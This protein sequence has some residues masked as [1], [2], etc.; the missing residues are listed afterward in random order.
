MSTKKK[1]KSKALPIPGKQVTLS[2]EQ[3]LKKAIAFQ[4]DG[5]L[6]QA[7]AIYEN[8][9][10]KDPRQ[11][12]AIHFL[13]VI[14]LQR[15]HF[16]E[17][18]DYL[19][20]AISINPHFADAL[21]HRGLTYKMLSKSALALADYSKAIELNPNHQNAWLERGVIFDGMDRLLESLQCFEKF[22]ELTKVQ[23]NKDFLLGPLNKV[24]VLRRL[25]RFEQAI[26]EAD[27]LIKSA[28]N[29]PLAYSMKAM[30]LSDQNQFDLALKLSDQAL[31]CSASS[32]GELGQLYSQRGIIYRGLWQL[33]NAATALRRA[34]EF[35]PFLIDAYSNLG[36][37]LLD[38]GKY[39][40]AISIFEKGLSINP[41]HFASH[42]NLGVAK[43]TVGDLP[44]GY[45][46]YEW[47]KRLQNWYAV[48]QQAPEW[49]GEQWL[50][51]KTILV[52]CE[53]GMGDTI[54]FARYATILA[55]IAGRVILQVQEPLLS[56]M[57]SL[58]GNIDLVPEKAPL[59]HHDFYC[60][61]MSL[62]K[63]FGTELQSI[64]ARQSYLK[65]PDDK[66]LAWKERLSTH[67]KK[68]IGLVWS[69]GFRQDQ[70]E[71][72]A[73]NNRRNI[74]LEKILC[75]V[76]DDRFDWF[77]L[78]KGDP[79]ESELKRY[80]GL[81]EHP[82]QL[83]NWVSE[84]SDFSDTAALIENL[85]LVIS[86]DTSTAHLAAALGRPVW[87][88]NRFDTCWR[89]LLERSDS[90]WYPSVRLYRQLR[91]ESWG[92]VIEE[93]KRDLAEF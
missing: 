74:P 22:I 54:Q 30:V 18:L 73:V 90:P 23:F 89:W 36:L 66:V 41:E 10:K 24:N 92:K 72:W 84:L 61:M 38:Q 7:Q 8:I 39:D 29:Y 60:L 42:F 46:H 13:G 81:A 79:A 43:L 82:P 86:V 69:G 5:A 37:V 28:P 68:R 59:P 31:E 15:Q 53:Q 67:S 70:P 80:M 27:N 87:I 44:G 17:A 19:N 6:D 33:D 32:H 64:P 75:L 4:N 65:A 63:L 57:S 77:S 40:Q 12:D 88:M 11:F 91:S 76:E 35:S 34:I 56:I 52:R 20:K 62:P 55:S 93:I 16:E 3:V 71:L 51:D 9:L 45:D 48:T 49:T 78:Q 2:I 83:V 58:D 26:L 85:D 21:F 1:N 47:R 50:G 14:Y 25:K